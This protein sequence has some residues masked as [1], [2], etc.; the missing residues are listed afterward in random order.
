MPWN[1]SSLWKTTPKKPWTFHCM[2][3][4]KDYLWIGGGEIAGTGTTSAR[5]YDTDAT[6]RDKY[7]TTA[8]YPLVLLAKLGHP[9]PWKADHCHSGMPEF[10]W[11]CFSTLKL[12]IRIMSRIWPSKRF[13]AHSLSRSSPPLW[14]AFWMHRHLQLSLTQYSIF[15]CEIALISSLSPEW[16][17]ESWTTE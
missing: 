16:K 17:W 11:F 5:K 14:M 15:I 9:N 1:L 8:N 3:I 6:C 13:V 12:W 4:L 7:L 10:K 2:I